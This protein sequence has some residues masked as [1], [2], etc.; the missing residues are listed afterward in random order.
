MTH[1]F[2]YST[3]YHMRGV[4]KLNQNDIN[5][6]SNQLIVDEKGGDIGKRLF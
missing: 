2:Y 4:A 5:F 3:K 6:C 1:V